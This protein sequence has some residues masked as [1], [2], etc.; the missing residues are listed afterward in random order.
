MNAQIDIAA[1]VAK[2][3]EKARL[4][5]QWI[6][7]LQILKT[8]GDRVQADFDKLVFYFDLTHKMRGINNFTSTDA[9]WMINLAQKIL[10]TLDDDLVILEKEIGDLDLLHRQTGQEMINEVLKMAH[11][12]RYECLRLYDA[13]CHFKHNCKYEMIYALMVK[14]LKGNVGSLQYAVSQ[15]PEFEKIRRKIREG[16]VLNRGIIEELVRKTVV[17]QAETAWKGSSSS[18]SS[19]AFVP[20]EWRRRPKSISRGPILISVDWLE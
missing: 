14:E 11:K 16:S 20:L 17:D 2:I 1:I 8:C 10:T 15:V 13:L 18:S 19:Y 4:Q 7:R 5:E 12:V 3:V 9:E 6:A